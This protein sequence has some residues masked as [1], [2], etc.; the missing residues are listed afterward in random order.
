M[1]VSDQAAGSTTAQLKEHP[2]RAILGAALLLV[3]F[4]VIPTA[5]VLYKSTQGLSLG[6]NPWVI[7]SLGALVSILTILVWVSRP[8]SAYGP[9]KIVSSISKIGIVLLLG[10]I[11]SVSYTFTSGNATVTA[12]VG[13][14]PIFVLLLAAPLVGLLSGGLFTVLDHRFPEFRR[15]QERARQ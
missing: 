10:A 2:W 6:F 15:G 13:S 11:F 3:L 9:L 12:T 4:G 5:I 8:T 14:G 1:R 7:F